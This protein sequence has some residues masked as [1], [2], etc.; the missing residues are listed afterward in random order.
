[1]LKVY[2]ADP[3]ECYLEFIAHR[4]PNFYWV[5]FRQYVINENHYLMRAAKLPVKWLWVNHFV[6]IH[7][8]YMNIMSI[9]NL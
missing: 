1:M 7:A 5:L 4:L 9:K 2:A 3:S 8:Q 6:N